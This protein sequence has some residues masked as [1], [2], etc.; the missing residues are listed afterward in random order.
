MAGVDRGD[1][2]QLQ[3]V[4]QRRRQHIRQFADSTRRFSGIYRPSV[5]NGR[6]F[7]ARLLP[8]SKERLDFDA[9]SVTFFIEDKNRILSVPTT[10]L[11]YDNAVELANREPFD[12]SRCYR[13]QPLGFRVRYTPANMST[14]PTP[15]LGSGTS[16]RTNHPSDNAKIGVMKLT[17]DVL[18]AVVCVKSQ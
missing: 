2:C 13:N 17:S 10:H 8:R 4:C 9:E 12:P 3:R 5:S 14:V 11:T 16:P 7:R 15:T 6:Q 18:V 1:H